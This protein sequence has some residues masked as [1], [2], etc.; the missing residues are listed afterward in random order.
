MGKGLE[1]LRVLEL[2]GGVS[3]PFAAKL[4]A[5]L[6]AEV[7]KVEPPGGEQARRRG[8]FR[9]DVPNPEASGLFLALNANKRSLALEIGSEAGRAALDSLAAKADI[10][11]HNFA[12]ASLPGL[13]LDFDRLAALNPRLVVLSITPFGCT[14]PYRD[15]AAADLNLIHAG[16]WGW[17]CPGAVKE[18]ALPPSKPFGQHAL[19]QAGV[20]GAMAAMGAYYG[21][22]GSGVGEHIDLSVQEVVAAMPARPFVNYTYAEKIDTRLDT[23]LFAP[24]GFYR[25]RDG[26]IFLICVE[27][28]Q[29]GRLVDLMGD[30]GWAEP[31]RFGHRQG[32]FDNLVEMDKHLNEWTA[33][34][35][36]DEIVRACQERRI[37]AC[38]VLGYDRI[39]QQEQLRARGFLQPHDHPEAG[40]M[41][42]PGSPYL[43]GNPQWALRS[44]APRLGEANGEMEDLFGGPRAGGRPRTGGAPQNS[45]TMPRA[46]AGEPP[47]APLA[48]VRVLDFSWVWA[49]PHCTMMLAHLGAEIIKVESS[50]RPCLT[51]RV[52]TYVPGMEPG[53]NRSGVFNQLNQGKKSVAINLSTPAGLALAKRLAARCDVVLSNFATGVMER[54]GLG[55]ADLRSANPGLIVA[56]ISGFGLSGPQRNYTAY[57]NAIVAPAG[58]SAQT[59]YPGGGPTE[60]G[61]AYGD[62]NAGGFTAFAIAAALVARRR[63]GGGQSIDISLWEALA[64]TGFEGWLNHVLGNPPYPPM[65]NRDPYW[66]PHNLYR[67][68]G[69]DA[70]LSI[71][72]TDEA[73]W[74][75]LCRAME[76]DG[77]AGEPRFA[78]AASR[79]AHEDALDSL[80]ADWCA[81]RDPWEATRLLQ[82]AG[83][84]AF[85]SLNA[86]QVAHDPHLNQRSFFGRAP[87]PEVGERCHAGK[88]W[89]TTRR[90]NR[91][92]RAP[93]LGEHTDEV[94]RSLLGLGDAEIARLH[95]EQALG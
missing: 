28:D 52:G 62:P 30:P 55:E 77:L 68:A 80:I 18:P 50:A 76:N 5:D 12:P 71:A 51:R 3:A 74:L 47:P 2:G 89:R 26:E 19:I 56:A 1:G 22:A 82:T 14:G 88:P 78:D 66:A 60:V 81:D 39:L 61:L 9:G 63:H 93:L 75:A 53:L 42:F 86:R 41:V 95:Q 21:A 15:Y 65:G 13:G 7:V 72:V 54:L 58:I 24:N 43:L 84:P 11:I 8:P 85:P 38:P 59:G 46:G 49:G 48:G 33:G 4:M 94:L 57:G 23:W 16:G 17:L 37:C 91:A 31:E 92:G 32:R 44:P 20:H 29:W 67:C 40:R 69:D 27:D 70:W 83:V 87:H 79:K 45:G 73:Q 90:P 25:C 6:G 35:R 34:Q 64:A 36:A 10:L